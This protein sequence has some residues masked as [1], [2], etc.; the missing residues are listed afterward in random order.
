MVIKNLTATLAANY[1]GCPIKT[2][3]GIT[4][5]LVGVFASYGTCNIEF[6]D[7]SISVGHL[8]S[9]CQLMLIPISEILDEHAIELLKIAN[10]HP[11]LA[12]DWHKIKMLDFHIERI[13]KLSECIKVKHSFR[14]FE[15]YFV[16]GY[17]DNMHLHF[18]MQNEYEDSIESSIWQPHRLVDYLRSLG[19]DCGYGSIS[20]LIE[21]GIA[22]SSS[23]N[24]KHDNDKK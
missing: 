13:T 17:L 4:G 21:A 14:C 7:E 11:F 24:N 12:S 23:I 20:S 18:E 8:L 9:E 22:I 2:K 10:Y 16:I 19:Y 5:T 15:G 1:L 3:E 6:P